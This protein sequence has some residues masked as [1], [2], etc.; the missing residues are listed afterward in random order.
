MK[1]KYFLLLAASSLFIFS[2]ANSQA[3]TEGSNAYYG[4]GIGVLS[5]TDIDPVATGGVVLGIEEDGWA[6][7]GIAFRSPY[8]AMDTTTTDVA[9]SGH[10][11]GLA[12]RTTEKNERYYKIKYSRASLDI[13]FKAAG[14]SITTGS[15]QGSSATVGIGFRM[16]KE[17]RL[18]M[19]YTYHQNDDFSDPIH[20]LTLIYIWGGTPYSSSSAQADEGLYLGFNLGQSKYDAELNDFSELDDGSI[21]SANLDEKDTSF[22]FTLGYQLTP[23]FSVEGGYID[24]GEL[25]LNAVSDGSNF[26]SPGAVNFTVET[27]GLFFDVKGQLPINEQFSLYGKLGLLQWDGNAS[28]SDSTG[29]VS[30]D[31]SDTFFGFGASFNINDSLL[32]NVDYTLYNLDGDDIDVI[33][34]G[35]QFKL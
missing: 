21:I 8:T 12:F 7:E 27:D 34:V 26:Y 33:A 14:G 23:N 32:F 5:Q 30:A 9:F 1:L 16:D 6:F 11:I 18:E 25:H 28:I 17:A 29:G 3:G 24:L 4:L 31:G 10:D 35:V 20:Y 2:S 15:T 13:D 19:D 22:S